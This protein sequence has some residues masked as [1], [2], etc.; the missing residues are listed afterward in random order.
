MLES[1]WLVDGKELDRFVR[2]PDSREPLPLPD[3][4]NCFTV[5]ATTSIHPSAV[6]DGLIGDGL[7]PL[8]SALGQHDERPHC[9]KF[10]AENQ[11]TAYGV[12]HMALLNSSEVTVQLLRWLA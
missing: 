11:W 6:K 10:S 1:S 2:S 3:G 8:R 5:A 9:L 7:V 4:V 12:S